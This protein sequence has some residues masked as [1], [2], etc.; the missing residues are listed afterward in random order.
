MKTLTIGL[1]ITFLVV[2]LLPQPLRAQG[3]PQVRTNC[4]SESVPYDYGGLNQTTTAV[5]A[6]SRNS[7]SNGPA[8]WSEWWTYAEPGVDSVNCTQFNVGLL[9]GAPNTGKNVNIQTWWYDTKWPPAW[10]KDYCPTLASGTN[11]HFHTSTYVFAWQWNGSMWAWAYYNSFGESPVWNVSANR[12]E[13]TT[14]PNRTGL[15]VAF[16]WGTNPIKVGNAHSQQWLLILSQGFTHLGDIGCGEF[17]CY[18]RVLTAT[19][20]N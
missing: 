1:A 10:T 16:N 5:F 11:G 18:G 14:D 6:D 8:P 2:L 17:G 3:F 4:A 15:P 7:N 13:F 9:W 20:Y 12:C 19:W